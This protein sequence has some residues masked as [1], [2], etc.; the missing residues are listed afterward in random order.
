MTGQLAPPRY[1]QEAS[2]RQPTLEKPALL[3]PLVHAVLGNEALGAK[4]TTLGTHRVR[5]QDGATL[6]AYLRSLEQQATQL[7]AVLQTQMRMAAQPARAAE[8]LCTAGCHF[9]ASSVTLHVLLHDSLELLPVC[10]PD[11]RRGGFAPDLSGVAV[12]AAAGHAV[13]ELG[14]NLG[15]SCARADGAAADSRAR[16][17]ASDAGL[18]PEELALAL[19]RT[20]EPVLAVRDVDEGGGKT[21]HYSLMAVAVL[22]DEG[23]PLGVVEAVAVHGA[24]FTPDDAALLPLLLPSVRPALLARRELLSATALPTLA[25]AAAPPT[26]SPA[27][28]ARPAVLGG[29]HLSP[30]LDAGEEARREVAPLLRQLSAIGAQLTQASRC[31]VFVLDEQRQRLT[32]HASAEGGEG[33]DE[34]GHVPARQGLAGYVSLTGER[35]NLRDAY[36]DPRFDTSPDTMSGRRTKALLCVPI[37]DSLGGVALGAVQ[38]VNKAG[39]GAFS[40]EDEATLAAMAGVASACLR[41]AHVFQGEAVLRRQAQ[42][43]LELCRITSGHLALPPLVRAVRAAA[44]RLIDAEHCTVFLRSEDGKKLLFERPEGETGA[45]LEMKLGKSI[46][47]RCAQSGLPIKLADA[48]A[49]SRFEQSDDERSGQRTGSLASWLK[50]VPHPPQ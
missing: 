38:L 2:S 46:A 22:S 25:A 18:F 39:G 19:R 36:V 6:D 50:Y 9:G 33:G 47:G 45:P 43:L 41:T 15:S 44:C 31:T 12:A 13:R 28:P 24:G 29:S 49:D 4:R 5:G 32:F 21:S 37:C 20:G 11:G 1:L 3:C 10:S 42:S 34:N 17:D 7:R 48:Y 14:R 30:P 16:A 27:L 23:Q 26:Y 8:L 35:V 40:R